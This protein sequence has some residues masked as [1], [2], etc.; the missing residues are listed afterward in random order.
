MLIYQ[1]DFCNP[2]LLGLSRSAYRDNSDLISDNYATF[3]RVYEVPIINSRAP[4]S[5]AKE[6]EVGEARSAQVRCKAGIDRA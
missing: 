5:S 4:D 3:R 1:A 2:G 6:R